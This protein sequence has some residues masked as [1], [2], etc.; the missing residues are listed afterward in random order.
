MKHLEVRQ[1]YSAARHNFNS[2]LS[3]LSGDETLRLILD[4]IRLNQQFREGRSIPS[5]IPEHM[6][7]HLISALN[8]TTSV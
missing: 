7:H 2:F 6:I 8:E 4:I 1:K 3:V 5:C